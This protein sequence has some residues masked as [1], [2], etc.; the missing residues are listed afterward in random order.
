[1]PTKT[2]LWTDSQGDTY[3][4]VDVGGGVL[5]EEVIAVSPVTSRV[6]AGRFYLAG[7]GKMTLAL[8]GNV[9]GTITNPAGSG[10]NVSVVRLVTFGTGTS[11]AQLFI[12]PTAGLPATAARPVLNAL[13]GGGEAAVGEVKVDTSTDT[14]LSGGADTGLVMGAGASDRIEATLP[15]LVLAPG[16]SLGVNVPFAGAADATISVYWFEDDQQV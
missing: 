6:A 11:W 2:V 13:V 5:L 9:R 14:P 12:N 4:R 15:P 16:V 10:R 1:M 7:S 8:A 3:R